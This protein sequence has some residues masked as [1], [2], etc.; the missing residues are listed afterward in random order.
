LPIKVYTGDCGFTEGRVGYW[1]FNV[2]WRSQLS[3]KNIM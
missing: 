3:G 1:N 2:H